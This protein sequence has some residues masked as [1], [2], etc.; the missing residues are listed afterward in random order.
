MIKITSSNDALEQELTCVRAERDGWRDAYEDAKRDA[1]VARAE[2]TAARIIAA[3][4]HPS[5]CT[6][7]PLCPYCEIERLRADL[8]AARALLEEVKADSFGYIGNAN[9]LRDR[10]DAALAGER[11]EGE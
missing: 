3:T 1:E 4:G 6:L 11:R 2:L 7:G 10:I 9:G 8:A 5:P